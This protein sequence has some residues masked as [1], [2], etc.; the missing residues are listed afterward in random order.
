MKILITTACFIILTFNT[1]YAQTKTNVTVS[2][3]RYAGDLVGMVEELEYRLDVQSKKLC[4][5]SES[6]K[7]INPK[8]KFIQGGDGRLH[9]NGELGVFFSGYPMPTLSA[10]IICE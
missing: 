2:V 3:L 8:I 10:D 1:S 9:F 7:V 6:V 5:E 4:P